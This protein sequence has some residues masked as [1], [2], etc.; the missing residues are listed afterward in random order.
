[1]TTKED[2]IALDPLVKNFE[3]LDSSLLRFF[4]ADDWSIIDK[5]IDAE[6]KIKR[7]LADRKP[8]QVG[9]GLAAKL[10]KIRDNYGYNI[11]LVVRALE[12]VYGEGQ[13]KFSQE[14]E[15]DID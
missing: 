15:Y 9:S 3:I 10:K 8:F 11:D 6:K 14:K 7:F 13:A 5:T 2:L 12:N 4:E 1:V